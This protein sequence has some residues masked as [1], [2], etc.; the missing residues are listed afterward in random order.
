MEKATLSGLRY[1]RD[2][3]LP[4]IPGLPRV[5]VPRLATTQ[6]SGA[7]L[8]AQAIETWYRMIP[9]L[10]PREHPP[11]FGASG[12]VCEIMMSGMELTATA[13]PAGAAAVETARTGPATR[14]PVAPIAIMA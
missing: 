8:P 4:P 2:D 1:A 9:G 6:T 5:M 3:A 10:P 7:P 14:A 11:G 12:H 13:V